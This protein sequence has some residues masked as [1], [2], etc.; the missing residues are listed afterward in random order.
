[1]IVAQGA[2]GWHASRSVRARHN[3]EPSAPPLPAELVLRHH[4]EPS[5]PPVDLETTDYKEV[6]A[7]PFKDDY[8]NRLLT[9]KTTAEFL[10]HLLEIPKDDTVSN[11]LDDAER[12]GNENSWACYEHE[13]A[14]VKGQCPQAIMIA[15]AEDPHGILEDLSTHDPVSYTRLKTRNETLMNRL[16]TLL[17][18]SKA[19]KERRSR[20][21]NLC[22]NQYA[23][24]KIEISDPVLQYR[25]VVSAFDRLEMIHQEFKNSFDTIL[26]TEISTQASDHNSLWTVVTQMLGHDKNAKNIAT[27]KI[28]DD[29]SL[30][31]NNTETK[32]HRLVA[33]DLSDTNI[34]HKTSE[35]EYFINS[36]RI[37]LRKIDNNDVPSSQF[38]Q[39]T[40]DAV[41]GRL[42]REITVSNLSADAQED[43]YLKYLKTQ[44]EELKH[45]LMDLRT[46]RKK[47]FNP[48]SYT[49]DEKNIFRNFFH[50][51]ENHLNKELSD[52]NMR[53]NL[54]QAIQAMRGKV[55]I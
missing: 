49:P 5:A 50:Q 32:V 55:K 11:A 30:L 9:H 17:E 45:G 19:F 52:S 24:H 28:R 34:R 47:F 23:G 16:S 13:L 27:N 26:Q 46:V 18:K 8:F 54:L 3:I 25:E 43:L 33:D 31:L 44:F 38:L 51:A 22:M 14:M 42:D 29:I 7:S 4:V 37:P 21:L 40:L 10:C 41:N 53:I 36:L 20:F 2:I 6:I 15:P 12:T 35:L 39:M 48:L 1:M